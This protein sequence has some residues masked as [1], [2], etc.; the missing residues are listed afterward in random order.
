MEEKNCKRLGLVIMSRNFYCQEVLQRIKTDTYLGGN[1]GK[2]H[3]KLG[4]GD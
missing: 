2:V 4:E 3:I 1:E